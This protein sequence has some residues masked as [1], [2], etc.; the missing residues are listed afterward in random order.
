[1]SD[2]L[3]VFHDWPWRHW[4]DQRPEAIALLADGQAYSW[5]ALCRAIDGRAAALQRQGVQPGSGLA[6]GGRNSLELLLVYLAGLQLAARVLPLNPHMPPAQLE[7]LLPRLDIDYGW[8]D[9]AVAWP[10]RVRPLSTASAS[11]LAPSAPAAPW[12]AARPATLTL[13]SGSSGLPKG[14]V[15]TPAQHLASA[16]GLLSVMRFTAEDRWLLS[17]PLFHVSGQG[18][19]WR[20]LWRGAGLALAADGDLAQ[21]LSGCSHASLV[22]TQLLR[23]LDQ[24]CPLPALKEVLLGGAAIA[25]ALTQRAEAAGIACWCGYGMTE[26]AS[27]IT[28]KR[29][30][31]TPGVGTVLP[32]RALQLVAGEVWV[33]GEPLALG[34]WQD[35]AIQPLTNAAG[36]LA[37][38]DRGAWVDGELHILGRLDH[39]FISGGENIQPED[40]EA[41]LLAYPAV[42]Q[43]FIV[44]V[45]DPLYG[46]RPLA[47]LEMAAG[48]PVDRPALQHWL[49]GRIAR[50]QW[51]VD[52]YPLP[53]TLHV[54]GIKLSRKAVE[55]W[56]VQ[57]FLQR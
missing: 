28:A 46:Q 23:L 56:A 51:P 29:A 4:R 33:R 19:V 55:E 44:A 7:Q 32:R 26:M 9:G 1:M 40:I 30:N 3:N 31:A 45:P 35:G 48:Q 25:P 27:T 49:S 11:V 8:H 16:A 17:L 12:Q 47:V 54:S 21:A 24:A 43:A 13:T 15:H 36:W 6:V 50:Y 18:I 37:T 42:A 14:V 22:P 53:A 5:A 20:W 38:R 57:E 10:G 39:M 2:D 34:V 52:Y 41:V